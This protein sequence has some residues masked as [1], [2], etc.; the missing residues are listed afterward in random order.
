MRIHNHGSFMLAHAQLWPFLH[1]L[2]HPHVLY[3]LNKFGVMMYIQFK[4]RRSLEGIILL[5]QEYFRTRVHVELP[6]KS[7]KSV[8]IQW[9]E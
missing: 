2:H 8:P 4:L 9:V 6:Y 3:L 7:L 1:L 5:Y